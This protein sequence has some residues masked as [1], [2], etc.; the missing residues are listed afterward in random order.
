MAGPDR[1]KKR[2]VQVQHFSYGVEN[3]KQ[4]A[5]QKNSQNHEI[6]VR[7]LCFVINNL[8]LNAV[9]VRTG[10]VQADQIGPKTRKPL[11]IKSK[12]RT[13]T[14]LNLDRAQSWTATHGPLGPGA[15]VSVN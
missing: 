11:I 14:G 6:L 1:T 15:R 4:K 5:D 3:M 7:F 10:P 13:K 2:T 9:L 12:K 8:S